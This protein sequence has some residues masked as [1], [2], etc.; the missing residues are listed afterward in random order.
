MRQPLSAIALVLGTL[1]GA[2]A[3]GAEVLDSV[4]EV[5]FRYAGEDQFKTDG[6]V[7]L[8]PDNAC[9]NWYIRLGGDP[10][11]AATEILTLPEALADWGDLATDPEDGI[12]ISADGKVATRSFVPDQDADG[13]FT[14][15][16]CVAAGDPVGAHS[17]EV[18]VDGETIATYDFQT[19]LPEDHAW[20]SI[21]QPMPRER[22]VDNSW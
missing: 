2:P 5:S 13:W 20:P 3:L 14:H 1:L 17:I 22:S 21:N 15:G 16:W 6:V 4:L 11:K 19:V 10:P 7:P 12:D 9:Y 8:L 18:A